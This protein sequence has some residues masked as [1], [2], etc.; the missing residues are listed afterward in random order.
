MNARLQFLADV[1]AIVRGCT[2]PPAPTLTPVPQTIECRTCGGSEE[3]CDPRDAFKWP[4]D[5][6]VRSVPCPNTECYL[7]FEK[8]PDWEPG[9]FTCGCGHALLAGDDC[10]A[11]GAAVAA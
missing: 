6:S 11:C 4:N 8:N 2:L 7:G 1:G 3:V 9:L 10:S 5:P